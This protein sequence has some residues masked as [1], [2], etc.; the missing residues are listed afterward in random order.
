VYTY[1]D[2]PSEERI[3]VNLVSESSRQ[4]CV[5]METWPSSGTVSTNRLNT[6]GIYLITAGIIY[7]FK[8]TEDHGE[9]FEG[10]CVIF[11]NKQDR[12]D[13]YLP[14]ADFGLPQN[15][16]SLQKELKFVPQPFWCER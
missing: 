12:I 5:A 15:S 8:D 14:Y 4:M 3:K 10:S 6:T 7:A 11:I 1:S 2:A 9:C 16:Y 13:G